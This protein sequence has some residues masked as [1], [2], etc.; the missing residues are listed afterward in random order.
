ML[1]NSLS[2]IL[3]IIGIFAFAGMGIGDKL[4]GVKIENKED[5][6]NPKVITV[7]GIPLLAFLGVSIFTPI[8]KGTILWI[9]I[10][11]IIL[12]AIIY[13]LSIVAFVKVKKGL[14][15]IGI[16]KFSRNPMYVVMF[17][18]FIAFILMAF[19]YSEKTGILMT[20]VTLINVIV[21][22]WM[23]LGEEK[24][25]SKKYGDIYREYRNKTPRYIR[26][27]KRGGIE[28]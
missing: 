18:I 10:F 2:F 14:N 23:V 8:V 28:K 6:H 26:M 15:T 11:I 22:H 1:T 17:L 16:Y 5:H 4:R 13:I 7:S 3:L 19:D 12:S 20:I 21:I 9:G 27:G 25:L 24:F